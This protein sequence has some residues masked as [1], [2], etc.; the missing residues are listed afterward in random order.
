MQLDEMISVAV[1]SRR[2]YCGNYW[3]YG[4]KYNT[5]NNGYLDIINYVLPF[6]LVIPN[7]RWV[8]LATDRFPV[9]SRRDH[10]R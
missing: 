4:S 9:L 3:S 8:E 10:V 6:S 1:E 2:K 7:S 5:T